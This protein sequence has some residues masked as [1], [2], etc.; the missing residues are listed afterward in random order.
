MLRPNVYV[1]NGV[2]FM[3][4]LQLAVNGIVAGAIYALMA[5]GFALIYNSTRIFH[6][7]HGALYTLGG[8]AFFVLVRQ[9]GMN[10]VVAFGLTVLFT[11][12]AGLVVEVLGYGPLRERGAGPAN[13]LISSLGIFIVMQNAVALKFG[14]QAQL[15][16]EEPLPSFQ[17]GGIM[18]TLL[19]VAVIVACLVIF[20]CLQIF[21]GRTTLGKGI[22]A[23]A[24]NPDLAFTMGIR[25]DR[26]YLVIHA[27]GAGLAGVAAA[28]VSLDVGVRP[29]MGL[30]VV[31]VAA[32]AVIIGGV[33]Y[34]PGAGIA[35]LILGLIQNLSVWQIS[36]Q[37]QD[38]IAFALFAL[39]LVW[40]PQ[41]I[42]GK[43]LVTRSS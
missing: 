37:W 20:P 15:L 11:A 10:L 18:V 36:A 34:L 26:L 13:Y 31:L 17:V 33:G 7:A 29:E 21:L 30:S 16:R 14:N 38:T 24:D 22:R 28:F 32:V 3:L 5:V 23:L 40:R 19:H 35:A 25:T 8:Y 4:L 27:V 2:W 9:V 1:R 12:A 41:G 39:F 42:F 43:S 6:V